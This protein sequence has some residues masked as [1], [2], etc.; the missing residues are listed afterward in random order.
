MCLAGTIYR[1]LTQG[2]VKK[3]TGKIQLYAAAQV[4]LETRSD[5]RTDEA[6]QPTVTVKICQDVCEQHDSALVLLCYLCHA[7]QHF[8]QRDLR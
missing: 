4:R 7:A 1:P 3:A 5:S 8:L 6:C 2:Q